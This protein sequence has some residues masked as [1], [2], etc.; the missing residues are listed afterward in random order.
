MG[1]LF[2]R[3]TH[4]RLAKSPVFE[5]RFIQT[6]KN[7][8]K[9]TFRTSKGTS[10][11]RLAQADDLGVELTARTLIESEISGELELESTDSARTLTRREESE[12]TEKAQVK[13]WTNQVVLQIISVSLLAF[14][15]V[16]SDIITPTFLAIPAKDDGVSENLAARSFFELSHGFGFSSQ[17]IG[18][19]LL[20]QAAVAIAAQLTLVPFIA[21]KFGALRVYRLVFCIFPVTYLFTPFL[22]KVR[23]PFAMMVLL[24]DLWVKVALSSTGYVCSAIL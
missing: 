13:P 18:F 4:P 7:I 8:F 12:P 2:L 22:A 15:K 5:N 3:E 17:K 16:S 21:S 6:I 9:G 23:P 24:L 20:T 1:L 19:I 14:H 10:Y 11:S